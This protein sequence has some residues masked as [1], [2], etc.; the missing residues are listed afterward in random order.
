M[1]LEHGAAPVASDLDDVAVAKALHSGVARMRSGSMLS[2]SIFL[3]LMSSMV[4][5]KIFAG[6]KLGGKER[7]GNSLK[8][9]TN[10]NT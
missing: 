6:L 8:V 10:W 5:S 7:G 3:V 1:Q 4:C 2:L 9:S